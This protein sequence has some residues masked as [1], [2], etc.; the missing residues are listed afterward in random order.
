MITDQQATALERVRQEL[1]DR[2]YAVAG[3]T[4]LG[5]D[6][7]IRR[8][9]VQNYFT[10]KVLE[11]D[12]P[13]VHLD[14]DRARDVI[15]Y[16][17]DGDH[18]RVREND[19][20]DIINRSGFAGPRT[21]NRVELLREGYMETWV[22]AMIGLIPPHLRQ[23]EGTFGVNFMRTR[24]TVVSGPHH[25]DE[26]YVIVYVADKHGEGAETTLHDVA[27]P[28]KIIHRVTLAPGDLIVFR[29]AAYLHNASP[30]TGGHAQRD[31]L[32]CTVNYPDTYPLH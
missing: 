13:A 1:T 2:G 10:E 23:A 31:A 18:L 26:E 6:P 24:T 5:L 8:H 9:I 19:R 12:H 17:W 3:D 11:S 25:D 7:E 21:P 15:R 28:S 30:L 32:V 22:R 4:D 27:D 29:D 16:A 20:I 14:R